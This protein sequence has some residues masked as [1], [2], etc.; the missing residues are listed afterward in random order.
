VRAL[1]IHLSFL[2]KTT[3]EIGQKEL[4]TEMFNLTSSFLFSFQKSNPAEFLELKNLFLDIVSSS[5]TIDAKNLILEFSKMKFNSRADS[6]NNSISKMNSASEQKITPL[7]E[8]L[9]LAS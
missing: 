9:F 8:I 5:K 7:E 3:C 2:T 1:G 6:K 4:I